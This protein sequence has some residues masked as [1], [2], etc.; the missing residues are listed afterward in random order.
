MGCATFLATPGTNM[1]LHRYLQTWFA[2]AEEL[3]EKD[4]ACLCTDVN[5]CEVPIC[6]PLTTR[7]LQRPCHVGRGRIRCARVC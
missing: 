4:P 7:P 1:H 3:T 5:H 2:E 6:L